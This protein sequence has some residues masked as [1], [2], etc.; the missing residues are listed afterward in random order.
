MTYE[1]IDDHE[2]YEDAVRRVYTETMDGRIP[3]EPN[4]EAAFFSE[5]ASRLAL[6]HVIPED[7]PAP[8]RMTAPAPARPA[9]RYARN[10]L[11][12]GEGRVAVL[13]VPE[14]ETERLTLRLMTTEDRRKYVKQE[15]AVTNN[16]VID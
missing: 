16:L 10:T 2:P 3:G 13:N 4:P 15:K 14:I 8:P 7:P 11:A 6:T 1:N 12:L 9:I 5:F